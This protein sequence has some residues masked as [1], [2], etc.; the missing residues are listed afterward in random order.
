MIDVM[1]LH[2]AYE[3]RDLAEVKWIR[4]ETNAADSTTKLKSSNAPKTLIDT[5]TIRLD[6]GEWVIR[7]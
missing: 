3:R 2:Q 7:D 4:G 5:N 1:N 6:V